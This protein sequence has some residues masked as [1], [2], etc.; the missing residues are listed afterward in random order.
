M[1][2]IYCNIL[3]GYDELSILEQK[4]LRENHLYTDFTEWLSAKLRLY[5]INE[6]L[7]LNN[8]RGITNE[9]I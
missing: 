8:L 9:K 5:S 6:L 1:K 3:L 7:K 4:Y 2:H